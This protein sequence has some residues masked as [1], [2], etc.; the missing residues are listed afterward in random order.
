[1]NAALE[2]AKAGALAAVAAR[3]W[4]A[5][6]G[7]VT[8]STAVL[9]YVIT[10][11][12]VRLT[13]Q[14]VTAI[15]AMPSASGLAK[16]K[17]AQHV[18]D[19][20][21]RLMRRKSLQPVRLQN[22][23]RSTAA[24]IAQVQSIAKNPDPDLLGYSKTATDGAPIVFAD[25][26]EMS[27][28]SA[29]LGRKATITFIKDMTKVPV[30]YAVVPAEK[31]MVSH[32]ANGTQVAG[33]D[34]PD[35][36][37]GMLR[38]VAGNGRAAG[39]KLAYERGTAAGYVA[40]LVED[41]GMLQLDPDAILALDRPMLVRIMR[42]SDVTADI[43]DKT[44]S[45]GTAGF[46][47]VEQ[48]KTDAERVDLSRLGFNDDGT[49][50]ME[51]LTR[52]VQ[53]MPLAEQAALAPDGMPTTQA[54]DRLMAATFSLAY[55]DDGLVKLYSQSLDPEIKNVLFGMAQ[56]AGDMAALKDA[57]PYDIRGYVTQAAGMA[58]NAKRSGM[59][60]S[61]MAEQ[62][63][64][65]MPEAVND[66]AAMFARNARSAKRIADSLRTLARSAFETFEAP[67]EDMFGPVE[68]L[69]PE[70]IVRSAM[71]AGSG[72]S[73]SLLDSILGLARIKAAAALAAKVAQYRESGLPPLERL[74][75]VR[76][77]NALVAELGGKPQAEAGEPA[78]VKA[79]RAIAK[80]AHDGETL[81]ELYVRIQAAINA[82]TEA[83]ALAGDAESVAHDAITRWAELESQ[84]A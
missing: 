29:L 58:S 71:S 77:I 8:V 72:A 43:G 68:K 76:D 5:F 74:R 79:L 2:R 12:Y 75:L 66:I 37:A 35:A 33:Y 60:L 25:Y 34:A 70:E 55:Q 31:V 39:I 59:P 67:A 63:D 16:L 23:D 44:N 47:A 4:V 40:G 21:A 18:S 65:S 53:S 6:D 17:A 64:M 62:R 27:V 41:A 54:L 82:L 14:L 45:S 69:P 24:S 38:A 78:E 48:A 61:R 36:P 32:D 80:G 73:G 46:S 28:P 49:P 56:S 81:L 22:R 9:D 57:G 51:A 52:F 42:H 84:D 20:V 11:A 1:M 7:P 83:G 13:S 10:P 19:L 50:T 30:Q 15:E 3:A 26:D